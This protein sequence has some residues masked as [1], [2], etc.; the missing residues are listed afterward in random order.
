VQTFLPYTNFR[1]SAQSL[2][3]KRLGKQRVECLQL[4]NSIKA[5]KEGK[6][7]RG[8]K[9]H[10]ARDMWYMPGKHDYSNALVDYGIA[11]CEA[12]KERGYKDT[13]LEKISAHYESKSPDKLPNW[14]GR[15]DIHESH[16]S[17]LIKKKPDYYKEKF[18]NTKEGLEYI[19]PT[20]DEQPA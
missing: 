7:Y 15:E 1:K 19:W 6:E 4:L 16:R 9:N 10:P 5:D 17:M 18:E 20:R 8:W 13:C 11:V 3:M 14:L 2:D 12:W